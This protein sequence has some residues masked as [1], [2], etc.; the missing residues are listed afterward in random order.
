MKTSVVVGPPPQQGGVVYLTRKEVAAKFGV[1]PRTIDNWRKNYS[2]P[3]Y[4][5]GGQVRFV[6]S[7]VDA[8]AKTMRRGK[9][10]PGM[11]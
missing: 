9:P 8:W 6:E 5:M 1:G 10:V 7:E 3:Y 11:V 4:R 2:M